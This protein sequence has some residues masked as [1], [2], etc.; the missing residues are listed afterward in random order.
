MNNFFNR[1]MNTKYFINT[2][3]YHDNNK[4]MNTISHDNI[5][6]LSTNYDKD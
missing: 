4:I 3:I 2:N 1:I 6:E 5:L